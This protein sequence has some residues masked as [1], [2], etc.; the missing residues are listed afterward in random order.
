MALQLPAHLLAS[1]QEPLN[2][3]DPNIPRLLVAFHKS[4]VEMLKPGFEIPPEL[5]RR[6]KMLANQEFRIF[7][8]CKNFTKIC[9]EIVAACNRSEVLPEHELS[10]MLA[11]VMDYFSDLRKLHQQRKDNINLLLQ[12][13]KDNLEKFRQAHWHVEVERDAV[14]IASRIGPIGVIAGVGLAGYPITPWSVAAAALLAVSCKVAGDY[15]REAA[16]KV[17]T[18]LA[19]DMQAKNAPIQYLETVAKNIDDAIDRLGT[20]TQRLRGSSGQ[21]RRRMDMLLEEVRGVQMT[22]CQNFVALAGDATLVAAFGL[23]ESRR[24]QI[25]REALAT[26]LA[27]VQ[28]LPAGMAP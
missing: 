5:V 22:A 1:R 27:D 8:E 12:S 7:H 18:A 16:E 9:E 19:K 15:H 20:D 28:M 10:G 24:L 11:E 13:D 14:G 17:A 2:V 3:E 6:M 26:D 21:I 25:V 23:T 4:H